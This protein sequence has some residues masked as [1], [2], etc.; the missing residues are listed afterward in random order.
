MGKDLRVS[1]DI[2][3]GCEISFREIVER[4]LR[5]EGEGDV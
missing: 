3:P 1:V 4:Q 2:L 5:Q